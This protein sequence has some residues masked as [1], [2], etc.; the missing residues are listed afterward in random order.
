MVW[1]MVRVVLLTAG[2][3]NEERK[4]KHQDGGRGVAQVP[5]MK[6]CQEF[7]YYTGQAYRTPSLDVW[8]EPEGPVDGEN[9]PV[10]D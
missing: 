10:Q 7:I 2:K 4:M 5:A 1:W 8:S 3:Q 9:K 6:P